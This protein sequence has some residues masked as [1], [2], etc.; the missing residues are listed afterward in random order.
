MT[1][2]NP[3]IRI[4]V[5]V[6]NPGQFFACCGLLELADRLWPGAEGWF[7]D[8][9]FHIVCI[10]TLHELLKL[11]VRDAPEEVTKLENGLSV[12]PIIAPLR[13]SFNCLAMPALTLDFW[14]VIKVQKGEVMAVAN[15][16][17]NFWGG[18]QKSHGIW[19]DL[20]AAFA[21]QLTML[22]ADRLSELFSQRDMLKGRFGF[23]AGPAWQAIDVGFSPNDHSMKVASSPA[24]ELLAA[25][26]LQ[27]FRPQTTSRNTVTYATWD[28]PLSPVV[29]AAAMLGTEPS[30]HCKRY[31]CSVVD[32]GQGYAALSYSF[33][34]QG[35]SRE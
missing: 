15:S 29:A 22:D 1:H 28:Q 14:M 21:K 17:W 12:K 25:V 34:L 32:R 26:G 16:P 13:F 20:K 18:Q 27:R 30:L 5:D 10:G 23:D 19:T 31:R 4:N 24:I 35:E 11:L 9:Q 33:L 8:R 2:T 3:S 6:T 7:E